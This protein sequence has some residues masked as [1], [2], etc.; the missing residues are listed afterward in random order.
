MS[1]GAVD[2]AEA[3]VEGRR[4]G[5]SRSCWR[6]SAM[7][8]GI[9][10][11]QAPVVDVAAAAWLL[12]RGKSLTR[13]RM[14][15]C[16]GAFTE[17]RRQRPQQG[18]ARNSLQAPTCPLSANEEQLAGQ[19]TLV[20]LPTALRCTAPGWLGPSAVWDAL[21]SCSSSSWRL[22]TRASLNLPLLRQRSPLCH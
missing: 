2:A 22:E 20:V 4:A 7:D 5:N 9:V 12:R 18:M 21:H 3:L 15:G 11:L 19:K 16:E 13:P 17:H 6:A 14:R 1:A 8:D 10:G